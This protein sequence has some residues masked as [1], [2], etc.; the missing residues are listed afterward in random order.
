M[1]NRSDVIFMKKFKW[2]IVGTGNICSSFCRSLQVLD[3]AEIYAVCSRTA[4][5]GNSFAKEF[6]AKL[7]FTDVL[8][9]AKSDVD[10]IYIGTPHSKHA[11]A[12][13]DAINTGKPV[14]CEKAFALNYRHAEKVI[15]LAREKELFLMEGLWTRFLPA[16]NKAKEWIDCG[17]IGEI[18]EIQ[19]SFSYPQHNAQP[20]GRMLNPELGGGALLDLGVYPLFISQ[21]LLG[22]QPERIETSAELTETGVDKN[23]TTVLHYKNG[24]KAYIS[25]NFLYESNHATVIGNK[26]CIFIPNLCWAYSAYCITGGKL[27]ESYSEPHENGLR[28]EAAHVMECLEKGLTESPLYP[29]QMTLDEMA[30]C[31][32][33]RSSWNLVYPGDSEIIGTF[34]KPS[35]PVKMPC[36]PDWWRD[37]VFYHIYPLGFCDTLKPNDFTSNPV[38]RLYSITEYA[39]E[40]A[41]KGFNALYLGPVFESVYHGYDTVDYTVVDRRLGENSD[42][43]DLVSGMHKNGIRV[44]LDGVF[45]HVGRDFKQ[46]R[47]VLENREASPYRYWFNID[48]G[49]NSPYNDGLWY[50][51][52]EGH[53][54]LVKL[55]LKNNEVRDY[56]FGCI[57]GWV[58]E[59][60]ID[61]LRLDVAYCLDR[62]FL[63]ALRSFSKSLKSDFFLLGECLHGDYN[64]WCND[65]MLD[66]VT[67]YECYKGLHSSFNCGNMH[68]IAYSLNRQFGSEHWTLY[69]NLPLYCFVDNHDVSRIATLLNDESHLPLIYSL[70]FTMP[71]IPSAYYGSEFGAKG[72]KSGG[73]EGLRPSIAFLRESAGD[74]ELCDFITKL[75]EIRKS[76]EAL[77]RGGYRQ[78]YVNS[79]Q[80]SFIREYNGKK[81]VYALNC[82]SNP[83]SLHI[84]IDFSGNDLISGNRYDFN[85][86]LNLGPYSAVILS[87]DN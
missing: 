45:N 51:G 3:N 78:L 77:C 30:T 81:V 85:G 56:I 74:T 36:N 4:E 10:I 20:D 7:V 58:D 61:G 54:N 43:A 29:L 76:S 80:L 32:K 33:L 82:D 75:C 63:C 62:D 6:N 46:F 41:A 31:D 19:A 13:Y 12:A 86:T 52:W 5:R 11:Q 72:D 1:K 47:D 2:G 60:D 27:T 69:K 24:K 44:I 66:S 23:S 9:M 71:G 84:G 49:G 37:S 50:E 64:Q 79:K 67:N 18:S 35:V 73:D 48:F 16:I 22:G 57:K 53:Y 15:A 21:W 17:L 38:R 39:S 25:T 42:L 83:A 34:L 87:I 59:F 55:N 28:F 8:E 26:G 70:L 40:I 65:N 14:L 68:E